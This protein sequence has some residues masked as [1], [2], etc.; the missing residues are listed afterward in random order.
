MKYKVYVITNTVNGKKYV[1]YTCW[2]LSRRW[3]RHCAR[4]HRPEATD[5]ESHFKRAI[6]KH[7]RGAFRS[8]VVETFG[9][10]K[11]ALAAEV[12]WIKKLD[13][14]EGVGYNS[15]AGGECGGGAS[16]I[17]P[18]DVQLIRRRY[19]NPYLKF[20]LKELSKRF[21]ITTV[22]IMSAAKGTTWAGVSYKPYH[23]YLGKLRL[24]EV[25]HIKYC[26]R[27]EVHSVTKL[28][29]RFGVSPY[30]VRSIGRNE[31]WTQVKPVHAPDININ[32]PASTRDKD[33][34]ILAENE[35]AHIKWLFDNTSLSVKAIA[36]HFGCSVNTVYSVRSG[37]TWADTAPKRDNSIT[38]TETE[39]RGRYKKYSTL[40]KRKAAYV[41][42]CETT[43]VTAKQLADLFNCTQTTVTNVWQ[44][45][46]YKNV[47][48]RNVVEFSDA[49]LHT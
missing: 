8:E 35:V 47:E 32:D 33:Y 25:A 36:E 14:F 48:P 5:Y 39:G 29:E 10:K 31:T 6:R 3:T 17:T 40:G 49:L 19:E 15:T 37:R 7:G 26:L 23:D 12:R 28:A 13:T 22:S 24:K 18:E 34:R 42:W 11:E 30:T 41:K 9:T 16:K 45:K 2:K 46:T 4:A 1:G 43:A 21:G 27:E 38:I 44:G 20:D